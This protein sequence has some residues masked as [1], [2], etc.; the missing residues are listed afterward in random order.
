MV[1]AGYVWLLLAKSIPQGIHDQLY[2]DS[3]CDGRL[4][5]EEVI[6]AYRI[7]ARISYF[8]P[9]KLVFESEDGPISYHLNMRYDE[10]ENDE[11][12]YVNA[13]GW[14]EGAV[15]VADQ[16]LDCVLV[17]YN[18]NGTF[19]DK[20]LDSSHADRIS[21]AQKDDPQFRFMGK[22]LR[23]G[24]TLCEIEVSRDGA[25]VA[26]SEAQGVEYGEVVARGY[27]QI[28]CGRFPGAICGCSYP[29]CGQVAGGEYRIE[30]WAIEC[31]DD[32]GNIWQVK[33]QSFRDKGVFQVSSSQKTELKVGE[34]LV[35]N[36]EVSRSGSTFS[37]NQGLKGSFGE[38]IELQRNGI[39]PRLPILHIKNKTGSYERTFSFEY[40]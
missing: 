34:P 24:E 25:F 3:D 6:K 21:V 18:A 27:H 31:K 36:L 26:F 35:A 20:A 5:N 15:T 1:K 29:W 39:R 9:I 40:G 10:Q 37:I 4:V 7:D 33:G 22:F 38:R 17:D 13:G 16:Q 32:L 19:D 30:H 2:I 23:L 14:Y 11:R 8:G 12:L 28:S